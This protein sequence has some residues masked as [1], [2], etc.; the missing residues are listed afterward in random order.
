MGR[1]ADLIVHSVF[2]IITPLPDM[3]VYSLLNIYQIPPKN[4]GA[5]QNGHPCKS[6]DNDHQWADLVMT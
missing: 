1:I 5:N 4:Q 2:A 3:I 6:H